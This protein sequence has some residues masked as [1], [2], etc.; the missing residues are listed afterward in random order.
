MLSDHCLSLLSVCDVGVLWSNGWM[1]QDETW[2]A[3]RP[4]PGHIML[5]RDPAPPPQKRGA[6][7]YRYRYL[8]T[9]HS[10]PQIS[11][12]VYCSQT[13]EWIKMKL[14]TDVG[15]L[16]GL[17]VLDGDPA[18]LPHSGTAPNFRPMYVVAKRLDGSRCRMIGR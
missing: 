8:L 10:S 7:R 18:P 12:D 14:G 9:S 13:A 6:Y 16:P 3:G 15:L 17:T 2:H 4:R 1:D 5:D 11:T